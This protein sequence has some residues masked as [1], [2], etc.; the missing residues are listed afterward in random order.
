[1]N[2][3]ETNIKILVIE[4][5]KKPY[6][7]VIPHTLESLQEIV[8]GLIEPMYLDSVAIVVN[9]EGKINGMEFNRALHH[10]GEIVDWIFGTFFICGLGE[11]DFTSL[12][13]EDVKKYKEQFLYPEFVINLNGNYLVLKDC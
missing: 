5:H 10:E 9:E 8:G 4:P 11:E 12:S 6:E 3:T 7:K 13:D 1:M 2:T